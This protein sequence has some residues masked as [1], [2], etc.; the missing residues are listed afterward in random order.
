MRLLQSELDRPTGLVVGAVGVVG[1]V[2]AG[3]IEKTQERGGVG[4][5]AHL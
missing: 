3:R 4:A 1:V 2:G 5:L